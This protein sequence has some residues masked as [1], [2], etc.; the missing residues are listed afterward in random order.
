[1]AHNNH[2]DHYGEEIDAPY[3]HM[4]PDTLRPEYGQRILTRERSNL[5]GSS[6]SLRKRL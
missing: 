5:S 2:P 4:N 6:Y 1:M 3:D